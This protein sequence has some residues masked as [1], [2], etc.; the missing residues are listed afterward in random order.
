MGRA[1]M[2]TDTDVGTMEARVLLCAG[3]TAA[4]HLREV[5]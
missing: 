4:Q 2:Q 3:L 5:Q 1:E